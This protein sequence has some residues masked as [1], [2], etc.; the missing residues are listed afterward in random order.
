MLRAGLMR[1]AAGGI[2]TYLPLGYRVLKKI[3]AIVREEMDA[4]GCQELML[5]IIQ[6]AELWHQTGRWA[7][8]GDEMFRFKDRHGAPFCLARPTRRSSRTSSARR[9]ARTGS[10]LSSSTR[11]KTSTGM[12]SAPVSA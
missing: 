7:E 11:F 4:A 12:R 5:P 9:S 2:Y 6:P 8:Y 3:M 1:K 10:F